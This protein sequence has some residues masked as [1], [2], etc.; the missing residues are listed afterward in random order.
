[1]GSPLAARSRTTGGTPI[2]HTGLRVLEILITVPSDLF[3]EASL[4]GN[5]QGDEEITLLKIQFSEN[6]SETQ[7]KA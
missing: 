1:M 3:N 5:E 2:D 4:I 7:E 6:G